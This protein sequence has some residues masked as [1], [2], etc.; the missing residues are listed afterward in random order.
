MGELFNDPGL[1]PWWAVD[2]LCVSSH[3]APFAKCAMSAAV[4]SN[5][6]SCVAPMERMLVRPACTVVSVFTCAKIV[7]IVLVVL[8]V[9]HLPH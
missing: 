6:Q 7:L 2:P 5:D 8:I 3:S 4:L 9:P 1:Y